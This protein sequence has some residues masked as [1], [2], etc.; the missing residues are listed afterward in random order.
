MSSTFYLLSFFYLIRAHPRNIDPPATTPD[1]ASWPL[2]AYS[3]PSDAD[4]IRS[5][6]SPKSINPVITTELV[7][8]GSSTTSV[9]GSASATERQRIGSQ[10]SSTV[11][12]GGGSGE[13]VVARR[14]PRHYFSGTLIVLMGMCGI[15]DEGTFLGMNCMGSLPVACCVVFRIIRALILVFLVALLKMWLI[16]SWFKSLISKI[17]NWQQSNFYAKKI[18]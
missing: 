15:S 7:G 14:K 2:H 10:S 18:Q 9:G 3:L 5:V 4:E 1:H 17:L 6:S 8:G 16:R 12:P 13:D 11:V